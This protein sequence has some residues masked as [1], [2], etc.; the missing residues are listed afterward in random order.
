MS[1]TGRWY[2]QCGSKNLMLL[3]S[4]VVYI[5]GA[6]AVLGRSSVA[7]T[8]GVIP[9]NAAL[10]SDMK[11]HHVLH[12]G[13][14]VGCERLSLATF[15]YVGFDGQLHDGEI[16]VMDAVAG[17]VLQIFDSLRSS[18]FPIAKA[19]LM[20]DYNGDDDA[21]MAD[22]NT[23]AFNHRPVAGRGLISLHAYGL[24]IDLNPVQNPTAERFGAT[25][26]FTF[27]PK[28]GADY[29][30]RLNDRP[31]K[32]FRPGMAE[33]VVDLFADHGFLVWGGYWDD[34]IDYQHFDVGRRFAKQLASASS[35][36]ASVLFEQ[37]VQ[38][39]RACRQSASRS[40]CIGA[41]N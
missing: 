33:P 4:V 10:C 30:N 18:R 26:R 34:P 6:F 37:H 24:A 11:T 22:N 7:S 32:D 8:S 40:S 9:V 17:H 16:A 19:R 36:E 12:P 2:A 25:A 31:G 23:S 38:R 20:N 29:A 41:N 28:S 35:E 15:R 21:S 1:F 3:L 5:V 14:P 27:R 13:A 39:Y